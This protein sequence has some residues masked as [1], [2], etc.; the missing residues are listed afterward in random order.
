MNGE[1]FKDP[2]ADRAIGRVVREEAYERFGVRLGQIVTITE[3][4]EGGKITGLKEA[5]VVQFH[6][7]LRWVRVKYLKSGQSEC[8]TPL[9]F[10][11]ARG[12]YRE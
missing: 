9:D 10:R 8:F 4:N 2:T 6:R 3:R 11:R 1:G 7:D 5:K 12:G